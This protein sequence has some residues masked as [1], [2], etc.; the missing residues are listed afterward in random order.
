MFFSINGDFI[1]SSTSNKHFKITLIKNGIK[2]N[3]RTQYSIRHNFMTDI[4]GTINQKDVEELM[5]HTG[6]EACY[7]HRTPET[8][9]KQMRDAVASNIIRE[10]TSKG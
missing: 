10:T 7:D 6:W 2:V 8:I 4:S 1:S 9:V 5:G 3:G